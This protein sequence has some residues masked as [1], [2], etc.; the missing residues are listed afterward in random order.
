MNDLTLTAG[1]FRKLVTP[2]LTCVG[3]D[4]MLPILTAIKIE[5]R[6]RWLIASATDRFKLAIKRVEHPDGE[7]P[8]FTA[9]VPARS[10][11]TILKQFRPLRGHLD[12]ELTL[13]ARQ[14]RLTVTVGGGFDGIAA[15]SMTY[16]L[17]EGEFPDVGEIVSKTLA[18]DQA[19]MDNSG[20]GWK[21]FAAFAA[22][23]EG[24][25]LRIRTYGDAKAMLVLGPDFVGMVM[26]RRMVDRV[27]DDGW[28][29][30]L[31]A[32]PKKPASRAKKLAVV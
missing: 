13:S 4:D 6:G 26:P 23:D 16:F 20:Y 14:D 29:E 5:T 22:A 27:G 2:V 17:I 10:V 11:Q 28:A 8:E 7:W 25:G 12:P 24:A 9:L 30:I 18:Q 1:Q 32:K 19:A 3:A 15:A 21:H 31:A